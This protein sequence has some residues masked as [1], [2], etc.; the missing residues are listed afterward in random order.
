[1]NINKQSKEKIEYGMFKVTKFM[2]NTAWKKRKSLIINNFIIVLIAVFLSLAEL[3]VTPTILGELQQGANSDNIIFTIL[4]FSILLIIL[5]ALKA[6]FSAVIRSGKIEVRLS[7]MQMLNNKKALMS[8]PLTE[9]ESIIKKHEKAENTTG[10]NDSA[11][12][13]I[14]ETLTDVLTALI[15]L[16]IYVI[17]LTNVNIVMICVVSIT[18]ALSYFVCKK[19]NNWGYRHTHE[20]EELQNKVNYAQK[21]SEDVEFA[22]DIRIF[23]MKQWMDDMYY[24]AV[25]LLRGFRLKAEKKY[26]KAD[27]IDLLLTFARNAIAYIYLINLSL[28][29]EITAPEFL[30]YFSAISA[31]SAML[32]QF[33]T[34]MTELQKKSIELRSVLEFINLKEIFKFEDG[35]SIMP[36]N[37]KEYEIKLNNVSFKYPEAKNYTLKNINLTL[38][39]G[40]KLAVVGLNGA[41]K[42]TF[43]KLMCGFYDPSEGEVLLNGENIIH[44][45]RRDYYKFFTAVFQEFSLLAGTIAQNVTQSIN[46]IDME[47]VKDV[48]DKAGLTKKIASLAKGMQTNILKDV[49]EDGIELSGGETQRLMLARALYKNSPLIVLDEPTAALDP[50]AESDI[51]NKYNEMTKG[52]SCVYISHRLASTR[53]C[54]RIILIDSGEIKEE[55]THDELIAL[56]GIYANLFEVQSKYYKEG[57]NLDE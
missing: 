6:Y 36:D 50:L 12:E 35:K 27:F 38:K 52:K 10:A 26:I 23:G 25:S 57:E 39:P 21:K 48:I 49:Y 44:F 8:Y 2:L 34:Q 14:W 33:L 28:S 1:M 51:Y 4:F 13:A 3:F 41:G 20:L 53:F 37:N 31:F 16:I 32:V 42:T 17:L 56:N 9:D 55:G 40:E 45:N 46:D 24:S 18:C 47:R 11:S 15:L 22:K 5:N 19:I 7:I 43:V 29:A 30:L 54:D